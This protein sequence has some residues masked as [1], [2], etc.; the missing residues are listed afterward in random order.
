M[1]CREMSAA[2]VDEALARPA[3]FEAHLA[4]CPE[5]GAL[6]RLHASASALRLPG[7]PALAP[8]PRPAVVGEVRRRRHRRRVAAGG[9]V[10]FAL[11]TLVLLALPRSGPEPLPLPVAA[12]GALRE[13][14]EPAS[15]GLLLDE[16]EAYTRANPAVED[17]N[18]AA[19]GALALWV[20]PPDTTA[21]NT[22]PFRTALS[23]LYPTVTQE[24][25]R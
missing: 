3:G 13:E 23:P 16:V 7:P 4:R 10:S 18:Y 8:I 9:V 21:L 6:A 25:A 15:L 12:E 11:A 1:S 20:R 5:C 2:I 19:F 17:E 14:G 22:R 24:A